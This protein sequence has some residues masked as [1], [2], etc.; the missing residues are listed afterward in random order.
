M[1]AAP[2]PIAAASPAAPPDFSVARV[3]ADKAELPRIRI[4]CPRSDTAEIVV[5]GRG[6]ARLYR[7]QPLPALPARPIAMERVR[8]FLTLHIGSATLG[9][10]CFGK[11][12]GIGLRIPF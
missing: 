1:Q 8:D 2:L 5:C 9:P 6:T 12:A 4:D 11:C 7:L 10:G 3:Q